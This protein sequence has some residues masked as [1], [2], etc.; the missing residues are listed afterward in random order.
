MMDWPQGVGRRVLASVDSTMAEGARVA[1]SLMGPEWILTHEQTAGHGRRGRAWASPSGN[2]MAS[3]VLRPSE[4]PDQ[5]AL[6]S[7]V[8]ALAL[9]EAFVAA[10]GREN[11]FK[12]K[13]PNDVLLNGGKVA[14][15]LLESIGAG[16][17]VDHLIIGIGVNLVAAPSPEQVEEGATSPV[18]LLKEMGTRLTPEAFLDLL[19]PAYARWEASFTTYGFGSIRTAWLKDAARVGEVITAR[20]TKESRTG[21]FET[22]DEA[23]NLILKTAKGREVITAAEIFF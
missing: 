22:V 10:T 19:A 23:G 20:T 11:A 1:P 14:G 17:Q 7:F 9:R 4:P 15:I 5:V 12:L 21:T 13:W 16:M 3:L 2:F 18:S 8:A 6:R